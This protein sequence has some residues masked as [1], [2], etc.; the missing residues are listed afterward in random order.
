MGKKIELDEETFRIYQF[1]IRKGMTKSELE[2]SILSA[3]GISKADLKLH[4]SQPTKI[5]PHG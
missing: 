2:K 4:A 5:A 3:V 1:N